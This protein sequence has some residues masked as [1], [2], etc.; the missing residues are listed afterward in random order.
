MT[1]TSTFQKNLVFLDT[2]LPG[3]A[4]LVRRSTDMITMTVPGEDGRA[5]NIDIRSGRLYNQDAG[6]F[7]AAQVAAWQNALMGVVAGRPEPKDL[8]DPG[9]KSLSAALACCR[10]RR[11][12]TPGCWW[13]SGWAGHDGDGSNHG[14]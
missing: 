8:H 3:V 14:S 4:S 1:E 13:S 11:P 12:I 9:T 5:T 10:F 7:A 2:A 6:A